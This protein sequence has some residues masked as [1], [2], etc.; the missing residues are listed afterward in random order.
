MMDASTSLVL[1]HR[2]GVRLSWSWYA[3]S[4]ETSSRPRPQ[5]GSSVT[6]AAA[7]IVGKR[8]GKCSPLWR[9][10]MREN[11]EIGYQTFVSDGGEE[12]GAVRQVAPHG[13]PELVIYVENAGDFVVPLDAVEAVLHRK[14]S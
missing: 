13:R 4:Y 11:I 12:F 9:C 14:S 6:Y 7:G 5:L 8:D 2:T 3:I 10:I 1:L